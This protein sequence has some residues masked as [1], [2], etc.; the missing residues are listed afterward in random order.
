[1]INPTKS[2]LDHPQLTKA[3]VINPTKNP[4]Q[5]QS[6]TITKNTNHINTATHEPKNQ[7]KGEMGQRHGLAAWVEGVGR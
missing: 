1:M 4:N 2:P 7:I 5:T 6:T 3:T